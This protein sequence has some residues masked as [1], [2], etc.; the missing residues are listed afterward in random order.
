[1][2]KATMGRIAICI[3]LAVSCAFGV[4]LTG[5]SN[6]EE[7]VR[8][9]VASELDA[10]KEL[11]DETVEM[12]LSSVSSEDLSIL[13]SV[14]LGGSDFVRAYLDGFDYSIEAVDVE[15]DTA[16]VTLT[17]TCKTYADLQSALEAAVTD[18]L[19]TEIVATGDMTAVGRAMLDAISAVGPRQSEPAVI[20]CTRVDGQWECSESAAE[21]VEGLMTGAVA[22][23]DDGNAAGEGTAQ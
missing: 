14:G 15:G 6:A 4:A 23:A 18:D 20:E 9:Q 1:M 21:V 13:E 12:L 19:V 8:N 17:L 11:D 22:P 5:C 3:A 10:V 2:G 7:E 16:Q